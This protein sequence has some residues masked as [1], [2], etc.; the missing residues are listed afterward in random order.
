[1][2]PINKPIDPGFN[3][4]PPNQPSR[5]PRRCPSCGQMI[6]VGVQKPLPDN[7]EVVPVPGPIGGIRQPVRSTPIPRP[8]G[9]PARSP[10]HLLTLVFFLEENNEIQDFIKDLLL[11]SEEVEQGGVLQKII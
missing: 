9:E 8:I 4:R 5:R 3:R 2:P 7:R 11:K 6:G 1:M 10:N